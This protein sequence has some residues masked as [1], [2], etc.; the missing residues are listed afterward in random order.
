METLQGGKDSGL[1]S[2]REAFPPQMA[3][4]SH[5]LF[6]RTALNASDTPF[7]QKKSVSLKIPGVCFERIPAQPFFHG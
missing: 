2:G 4:I 6:G 3:E 5:G 7:P 1:A